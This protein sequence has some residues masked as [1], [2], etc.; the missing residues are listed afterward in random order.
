MSPA[1][2]CPALPCPALPVHAKVSL[3]LRRFVELNP[4]SRFHA[5]C[6]IH[7]GLKQRIGLRMMDRVLSTMHSC[8]LRCGSVLPRKAGKGVTIF[9]VLDGGS[10]LADRL[11]GWLAGEQVLASIP[12]T[13]V[14]QGALLRCQLLQLLRICLLEPL[15]STRCAALCC[16]CLP[17]CLATPCA[18]GRCCSTSSPTPSSSPTRESR[19]GRAAAAAC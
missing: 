15:S 9:S 18:C 3:R 6:R 11:A 10:P 19:R 12:N 2:P 17:W 4:M 14:L 1:L 5:L 16:R 13:V 7:V 8:E